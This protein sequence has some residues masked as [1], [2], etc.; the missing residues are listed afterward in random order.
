MDQIQTLQNPTFRVG[1][2]CWCKTWREL[3]SMSPGFENFLLVRRGEVRQNGDEEH[4]ITNHQQ[5]PPT[6][7]PKSRVIRRAHPSISP[8]SNLNREHGKEGKFWRRQLPVSQQSSN[9]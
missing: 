2:A 5:R 1:F 3:L 6:I 8:F 4:S 9:G 7:K